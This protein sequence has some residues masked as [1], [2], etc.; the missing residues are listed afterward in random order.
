MSKI[1]LKEQLKYLKG[2]TERL[3]VLHE[4]QILQLRN[5][6]LL[7]PNVLT[8]ETTVDQS[9]KMVKF[10]CTSKKAPFR[11][12]K[13]VDLAIKNIDSWI[14]WIIW[15]ETVVEIVVDGKDIYDSRIG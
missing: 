4:A 9:N 12:T 14:R 5:Y 3:G 6:P 15:D 2:I 7:I 11:K 8:A 1:P 13:K 10:K